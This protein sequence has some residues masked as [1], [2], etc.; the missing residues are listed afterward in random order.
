MTG[1]DTGLTGSERC[2]AKRSSCAYGAIDARFEVYVKG[3]TIYS[4]QNGGTMVEADG[5]IGGS[6]TGTR[7]VSEDLVDAVYRNQNLQ[8]TMQLAAAMFGIGRVE[9]SELVVIKC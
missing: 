7:F 8:N 5:Y 2:C 3:R 6:P 1:E 4:G 9:P